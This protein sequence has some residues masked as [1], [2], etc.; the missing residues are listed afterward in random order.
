MA[1]GSTAPGDPGAAGGRDDALG[2]AA[3]QPERV[4]DGQHHIAGPRLVGVA[5]T[6]WLE[7]GPVGDPDHREITRGIAAHQ[8]PSPRLRVTGQLD[9]KRAGVPSH[10]RVG[11]NVPG[12]VEDHARAQPVAGADQHHRRQHLADHVGVAVALR[13]ARRCRGG[14][15]P[16]G[17]TWSGRGGAD[18]ETA[19]PDDRGQG[20]GQRGAADSL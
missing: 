9:L 20:G 1:F 15:R 13:L 4:A 10:V 6:G 7:P 12:V 14:G 3:G 19:E 16:G 17:V 18:G 5:E 2:H 11:D 8:C